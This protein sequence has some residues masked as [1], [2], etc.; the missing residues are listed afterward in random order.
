MHPEEVRAHHG[1]AERRRLLLNIACCRFTCD[2]DD[3]CGD[4]SDENDAVCSKC[5]FRNH[6]PFRLRPLRLSPAPFCRESRPQL[7]RRR[8]PLQQ[9]QV[10]RQGVEVRG[11]VLGALRRTIFPNFAKIDQ[12]FIRCDNDDD[13]GDNSDEPAECAQEECRRGWTRCSGSYRSATVTERQ[14]GAHDGG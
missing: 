5:T 6:A 8:V 7:H 4:R 2:G 13:C 11:V 14:K 9:P 12:F 1:G 10:H 3:D